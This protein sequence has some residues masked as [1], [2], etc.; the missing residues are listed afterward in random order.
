MKQRV[1]ALLVALLL[2]GLL[3]V[4]AEVVWQP[5][6]ET[7]P[8]LWSRTG[9]DTDNTN[10]T[11]EQRSQDT[12]K[13][14]LYITV[15]IESERDESGHLIWSM[16]ETTDA[17][18]LLLSRLMCNYDEQGVLSHGSLTIMN[19]AGEIDRVWACNIRQTGE[20]GFATS[21]TLFDGQD[22]EIMIV[23]AEYDKQGAFLS[24][25]T[26]DYKTREEKPLASMPEE[27]PLREEWLR[28]LPEP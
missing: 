18:A 19:E 4:Q 16:R 22:H 17:Q 7:T 3:P 14:E 10:I 6:Q 15:T 13:P 5:W 2:L 9:S 21:N 20:G 24:G 26:I 1:C 27:D 23:K 28:L 11:Y 8:G 12:E 25:Q